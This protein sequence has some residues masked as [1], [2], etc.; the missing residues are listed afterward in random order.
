LLLLV[1]AAIWLGVQPYR[2]RDFFEWL[3]VRPG[4]AR[5]VGSALL[6]YG[7]V[8]AVVAFTY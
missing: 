2:L 5:V 3:F 4:R 6:V 1:P 8:V 7:L